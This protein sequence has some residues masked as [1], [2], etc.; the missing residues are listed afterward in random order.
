MSAKKIITTSLPGDLIK[1]LKL[2]AV[3]NDTNMNA[4]LE[5][6]LRNYLNDKKGE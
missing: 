3:L 2:T 1:Q 6:A 5:E 4:I